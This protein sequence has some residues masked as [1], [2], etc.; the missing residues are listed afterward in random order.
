M[1]NEATFDTNVRVIWGDTENI[2]EVRKRKKK[3]VLLVLT[4]NFGN[5][6]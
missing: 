3:I 5:K 2:P 1:N 4:L 6:Y